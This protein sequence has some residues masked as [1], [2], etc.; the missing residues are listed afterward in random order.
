MKKSILLLITAALIGIDQLLKKWAVEALASKITI[1]V[2]P[3][4]FSL[5]YVENRG[6]A[7]GFLQGRAGILAVF[8]GAILAVMAFL[9]FAGRLK[10]RR[11]IS[12]AVL[13]LAGG[14][15]NLIDRASQGFVVDYL[16][17]SPL[18]SFPVFN[19]ADCC[20]VIG[21]GLLAW[22]LISSEISSHNPD[23]PSEPKDVPPHEQI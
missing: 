13:I 12:G 19:F 10:G 1:P 14:V 8:T 17:V 5:T 23:L 15:G 7:F 11:L 16:D 6:A 9:L 20:V 21:T 4:V 18:I 2:I 22:Y 3:R